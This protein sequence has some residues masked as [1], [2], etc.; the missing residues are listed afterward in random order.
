M[1]VLIVEDD[2][3]IAMD[4]EDIVHEQMSADILFGESVATARCLLEEPLDFALFDVDVPGGKTY[5]LAATLQRRNVPFA[6]VSGSC[7]G[8]LPR[9]LQGVPFVAKPYSPVDVS[10]T[11]R[12]VANRARQPKALAAA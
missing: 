8:E 2:P 12:E 10:R 4:L 1:L 7:R 6:F 11:I 9:E 3:M 5:A